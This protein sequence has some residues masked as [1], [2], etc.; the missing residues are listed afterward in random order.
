MKDKYVWWG[1]LGIGVAAF[2]WYLTKQQISSQQTPVQTSYLVPQPLTQN[3]GDVASQ[4]ANTSISEQSNIVGTHPNSTQ[5]NGS[6][7]TF[8]STPISNL[9]TPNPSTATQ[10]VGA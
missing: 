2:F 9:Q 10:P 3:Q 5:S 8:L 1:V 4:S 7:S 6:N